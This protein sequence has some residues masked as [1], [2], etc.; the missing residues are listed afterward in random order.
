MRMHLKRINNA[1]WNLGAATAAA[2]ILAATAP[3]NVENDNQRT[4]HEDGHDGASPVVNAAAPSAA[5]AA[6]DIDNSNQRADQ[7]EERKDDGVRVAAA[8]VNK[9]AN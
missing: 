4:D 1:A 6:A 9:R 8:S 5:T 3:T 2:A 7:E